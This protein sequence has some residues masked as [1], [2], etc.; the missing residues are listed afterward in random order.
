M[1]KETD[2]LSTILFFLTSYKLQFFILFCFGIIVAFLELIN[3]AL[4][5]PILSLST[6]QTYESNNVVY[7]L[8]SFPEVAASNLFN[9]HDPL[10]TACLLFILFAIL[11]YI[12]NIIYT[13]ISL[14]ITANITINNKEKVF[15]KITNLDYQYFVDNKQGEIIYRISRSTESISS[16]FDSLSKLFVDIIISLAILSLMLLSSFIGTL[17]VLIVGGSFYLLSR[18]MSV[19]VAFH[20]GTGKRRAA[21]QENVT[22]NEYL[23]GV[24]QIKASVASQYWDTRFAKTIREYWILWK[25][26]TFWL[27]ALILLLYLLI[28]VSIGTSIIILK[29]INPESFMVYI[30]ILGVFSLGILKILP[31]LASFSNCQMVLMS[32][33]PN[34]KNV[35][36]CLTDTSYSSIENGSILLTTNKPEIELRY[37]C[38]S[39]KNRGKLLDGITLNLKAGTTTALV[40]PSGSGKSTIIDLLLRLYDVDNGEVLI[41]NINIKEYNLTQLLGKIGF[42][43]QETFI[44][45]GTIKENILFG[46]DYTQSDVIDA[47]KAANAH[48]FI[49]QLP[50]QYDTYVG[51]RG[52]KISGGERQ[53]IAIARAIVRK[54][55]ILIFDEAT[56]SLD[57]KS[58]KLVQDS[59]NY[60]SK[61]CTTLIVAHRLST[62]L[63]S[64]IIYVLKNGKIVESGTHEQLMNN[65]NEYWTMNTINSDL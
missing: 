19:R 33:L 44:F 51:D 50:Q 61:K 46:H 25:K 21:E 28:Y 64:D 53:R 48:E 31:K 52:V 10:I 40:G 58:E 15:N 45:N 38:Y 49:M 29:I 13:L 16:V 65:R 47:A 20:T 6:N 56:S 17:I 32:A 54:P 59:I 39:H 57:S 7:T 43:C 63:N 5:Y 14:R 35:R 60:I 3:L 34:L 8:I 9:I 26:E 24:K 22:I 62:I 2:S 36:D 41:N 12:F 1:E 27:Q 18:Y 23:N 11:S 30:P 4:L 55:E 37:V 42:V